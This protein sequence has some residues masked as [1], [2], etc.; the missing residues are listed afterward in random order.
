MKIIHI[1]NSNQI[2]GAARAA[3]RIHESL[4]DNNIS[5]KIWVNDKVGDDSNVFSVPGKYFKVIKIIK[6]LISRYLTKLLKTNN[7]SLHSP[8]IFSSRWI[9]KINKSKKLLRKRP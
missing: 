3:T 6:I 2:G 5:S 4:L 8:Q 1:S 7:P 9:D